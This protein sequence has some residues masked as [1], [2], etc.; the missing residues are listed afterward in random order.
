MK[1]SLK[2]FLYRKF[3]DPLLSGLRREVFFS[4]IPGDRILEI[5]C[6]TGALATEMASKA[7]Y[8]TAIDLSEENI[9]AAV[10]RALRNGTGNIKFEVRNASDL[11]CYSELQFDAAVIT[12]AVHQFDPG[13][14]IKILSEMRK[15]AS[16][17]IIGDYSHHM[18]S[19]WGRNLAWAIEW[20]AGGDHYRNFRNYMRSGGL[21]F[22][23]SKAGL[24]IISQSVRGGGV[25]VVAI[26]K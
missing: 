26:C 1:F 8:V 13:Q 5:A 7:A 15:K 21:H 10:H 3:I 19:G 25:F 20:L 14:A 12:M 23:A 6:G 17:V 9:A 16:R 2:V 24:D 22:F 4:I 11:S 18:R